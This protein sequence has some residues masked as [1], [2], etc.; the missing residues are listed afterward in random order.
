VSEEKIDTDIETA[1]PRNELLP[2]GFVPLESD[3]ED[4]P[5]QKKADALARRFRIS[6]TTG[7]P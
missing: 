1:I 2:V 4:K 6:K 5:W 3:G 7:C